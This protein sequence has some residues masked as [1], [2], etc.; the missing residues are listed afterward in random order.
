MEETI[1]EMQYRL[2]RNFIDHMP[3]TYRKKTMNWVIVR[4]FLQWGTSKGG[5]TS[6]IA[7]CRELG[8]DPDGY[9]IERD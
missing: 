1:L 2:L 4:D 9:T 8:I 5:S 7:K 6:S 3:K